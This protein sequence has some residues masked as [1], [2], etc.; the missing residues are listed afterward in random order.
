MAVLGELVGCC[1][2]GRSGESREGPQSNDSSAVVDKQPS[3]VKPPMVVNA[4]EKVKQLVTSRSYQKPTLEQLEALYQEGKELVRLQEDA[5]IFKLCDDDDDE[6]VIAAATVITDTRE[7]KKLATP[8]PVLECNN[9]DGMKESEHEPSRPTSPPSPA[10]TSVASNIT[11]KPSEATISQ[12][13]H[14][15]AGN[16]EKVDDDCDKLAPIPEQDDGLPAS[17]ATPHITNVRLASPSI[18]CVSPPLPWQSGTQRSRRVK[19]WSHENRSSIYPSDE[20]SMIYSDDGCT[21]RLPSPAFVL[22]QNNDED[23]ENRDNL[24]ITKIRNVSPG[25]LLLRPIFEVLEQSRRASLTRPPPSEPIVDLSALPHP[26]EFELDDPAEPITE[27]A[28]DDNVSVA[29]LLDPAEYELDDVALTP[30]T[31][32]KIKPVDSEA[33][34]SFIMQG[35]NFLKSEFDRLKQ[36]IA[37]GTF[38]ATPWD[39]LPSPPP[40]AVTRL[41]ATPGAIDPASSTRPLRRSPLSVEGLRLPDLAIL[42]GLYSIKALRSATP[43]SPLSPLSALSLASCN[44]SL[45]PLG[46]KNSGTFS[47]SIRNVSAGSSFLAD[48]ALDSPVPGTDAAN[49]EGAAEDASAIPPTSFAGNIQQ[50]ITTGFSS[51]LTRFGVKPAGPP[52]PAPAPSQAEQRP[53]TPVPKR[54]ARVM[55]AESFVIATPPLSPTPSN[56]G[57]MRQIL[58]KKVEG[59]LRGPNVAPASPKPARLAMS[60]GFPTVDYSDTLSVEYVNEFDGFNWDAPDGKIPWYQ[61]PMP[62]DGDSATSPYLPKAQSAGVFTPV[63]ISQ[64]PAASATDRVA[65]S[66][67]SPV[68]SMAPSFLGRHL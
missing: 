6:E 13:Q 22:P 30:W 42:K 50:S 59:S 66:A 44:S 68:A 35:A 46:S 23:K 65:S 54:V 21:P 10:L 16:D 11:Q 20:S 55:S 32:P 37:T 26:D 8:Q 34:T 67:N 1:G 15:F 12:Q 2:C 7:N 19:L 52:S 47:P 61:D 28:D 63:V 5:E 57:F 41:P 33:P 39:R 53:L 58:G 40:A 27:L 62:W 48:K 49:H 9:Y 24:T 51:L 43:R 25:S 17:D 18:R 36:R 4:L 56:L 64:V 60:P 31:S 29:S 45:Q 3:L 14:S 38:D